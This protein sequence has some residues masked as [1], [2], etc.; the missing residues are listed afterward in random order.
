MWNA[1]LDY[2]QGEDKKT[3]VKCISNDDVMNEMINNAKIHM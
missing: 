1:G 2:A 3:Y